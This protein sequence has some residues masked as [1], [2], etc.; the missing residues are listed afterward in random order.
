[1]ALVMG[2]AWFPVA[3]A[4]LNDGLLVYFSFDEEPVGGIVAD[5]SGNGNDGTVIGTPTYEPDGV[6]GGAYS[7]TAKSGSN[8]C[9]WYRDYITLKDNPTANVE[10]LAVSLWIKTDTPSNNYKIAS[11]AAWHPGS[12]WV[13]G[14]QYPEIWGQSSG[15]KVF[16]DRKNCFMV[17]ENHIPEAGKWNHIVISY[18]GTSF[19]EYLN[20]EL[21]ND[22][23]ASGEKVGDARGQKLAIAA[24]PQHGFGYDGLIDDFRVYNRG[25]SAEEVLELYDRVIPQ[26]VSQAACSEFAGN[27]HTCTLKNDGSIFCWG[28]NYF[29]QITSPKGNDFIQIG[30]HYNNTCALKSNGSIICW[31]ENG[32]GQSTPPEGNNF[33]QVATGRL[34]TCALKSDGGLVCWGRNFYGEGTPPTDNNFIQVSAGY[35]YACALKNNGSLICWGVNLSK[36]IPPAGN[37]FSQVTAGSSHACALKNDGNISCWGIGNTDIPMGNFTQVSAGNDYTCALKKNGSLACWGL[38]G[39]HSV[40]YGQTTPPEGNDFI[41]ISTGIQHACALK[42]NGSLVCWGKNISGE[43]TPPVGNDFV[44]GCL[45]NDN[46]ICQLY[47]VHDDGLNNTQFFTVSPETFEVK[48]LGNMKEAHDIEALD[49][50]PQ[51]AELFAASGKDTN[52]PGHLYRVDKNSGKLTDIG[53]TGL[54]EIDGLSF[55][56][57]GTLWGWST[58]DGLVTIDTTTKQTN[59]V[60]AY[61]G[62]IEDL[63]WNTAGT[64]LF[65]VGNLVDDSSDTGTR[66]LAYD[67]TTLTMVCEELTQSLEIE[68]LDTLPDDT[69]LFGLHNRKNLPLGALDVTNCK[70]IA[71][72]EIATD[73]NDVEGIAWPNC[74]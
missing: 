15:K 3:W 34:H 62:E 2:L 55:H 5:E 39:P 26:T 12:G 36:T 61:P 17:W 56:P 25:V 41:Q 21:V 54:K 32:Y 58:G 37:N 74:Q 67:G 8:C 51:T 31:G 19:Q 68:A 48:A 18:N 64:I 53:S 49:I 33:I 65:G 27:S 72:Q 45:P 22:C 46:G 70:I 71:E 50:H 13:L 42:K 4:D 63:T 28:W 11:A 10:E 52:K 73:Y 60:A 24:W 69:L 9:S 16:D 35:D 6:F 44:G 14:T 57:D 40:N 1:M 43:S 20:G 29:D 23:P 59:L 66:L 30:T 47:A 38:S 7:F